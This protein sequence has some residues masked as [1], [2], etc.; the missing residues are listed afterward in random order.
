MSNEQIKTLENKL[1]EA[2]EY[3]QNARSSTGYFAA[4]IIANILS[5]LHDPQGLHE[6]A[7]ET[8]LHN[9]RTLDRLQKDHANKQ[10]RQN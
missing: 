7:A 4:S 8:A 5:G 10:I 3:A 1:I 2:M 9:K 6:L